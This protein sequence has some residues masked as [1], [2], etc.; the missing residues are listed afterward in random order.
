MVQV[1]A[2]DTALAKQV[3]AVVERTLPA[4]D[5]C[6]L[7]QSRPLVIRIEDDPS[8]QKFLGHYGIR[9]GEIRILAPDQFAEVLD[10]DSAYLKIAPEH[11]LDSVVV[12]ELTHAL[13]MNTLCGSETCLAGHEY[14]AYAMQIELLST[15]DRQTLIG[16][17]PKPSPLELTW[18]TDERSI[19]TPEQ[20]AANAWRHFSQPGFGCAFVRA[21]VAGDSVF[22][23]ELE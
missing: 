23:S 21:V 2:S 12:H 18:F 3:C 22:P 9:S 7:R 14:V 17:L 8:D 15:Q 20:F 4:L 11:L 10:A 6:G 5:E 13:F 1:A 19:E 16:A